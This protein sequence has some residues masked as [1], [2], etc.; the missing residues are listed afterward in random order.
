MASLESTGVWTASYYTT[1]GLDQ[2][3]VH[4]G[5]D[6]MTFHTRNENPSDASIYAVSFAIQQKLS[7]EPLVGPKPKF[8]LKHFFLLPTIFSLQANLHWSC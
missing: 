7:H 5:G 2:E 4:H 1:S 8:V 6:S 3:E